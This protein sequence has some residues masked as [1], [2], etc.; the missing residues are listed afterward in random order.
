[1]AKGLLS[2]LGDPYSTFASESDL[3]LAPTSSS[4]GLS[5]GYERTASA[6]APA[7]SLAMPA[8]TASPTSP[9]P[10]GFSAPLHALEQAT[11]L[12]APPRP[13]APMIV[14]GVMPDSP[15]EAAGLRIGDVVEQIGGLDTPASQLLPE[16]IRH[17]LLHGTEDGGS[18]TAPDGVLSES[19]ESTRH[20]QQVQRLVPAAWQQWQQLSKRKKRRGQS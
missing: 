1:M 9:P 7:A 3:E 12:P 14:T 17:L 6:T 8:G 15:A 11:T 18:A 2:A 10:H 19:A 4:F 20:L 13:V 16:Q 5:L